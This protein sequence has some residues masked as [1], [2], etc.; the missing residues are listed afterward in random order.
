MKELYKSMPKST[1]LYKS[2][3][4]ST[5]LYKSMPKYTVLYKSMPKYTELL[6]Q[7]YRLHVVL[8]IQ[9]KLVIV[10]LNP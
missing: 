7:K 9:L 1:V 6:V 4:K 3:P 2:M 8:R 10:I 5:V